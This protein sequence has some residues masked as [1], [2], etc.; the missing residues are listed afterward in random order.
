MSIQVGMPANRSRTSAEHQACTGPNVPITEPHIAVPPSD[1]ASGQPTQTESSTQ[2]VPIST[3]NTGEPTAPPAVPSPH[4]RRSC[5]QVQ[6][7][8]WHA[9]YTM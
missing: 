4:I 9:D 6:K 1:N 2:P 8:A 5:R 3:N 7:P